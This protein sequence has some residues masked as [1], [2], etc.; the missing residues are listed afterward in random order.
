[1]KK[2][3][4][5]VESSIFISAKVSLGAVLGW[6]MRDEGP[7]TSFLDVYGQDG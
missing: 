5:L 4:P 3:I 1:M 2:T 6:R 7:Y